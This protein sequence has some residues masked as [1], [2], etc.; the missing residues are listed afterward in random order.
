[1]CILSEPL[2]N[3]M[4]FCLVVYFSWIMVGESW[5]LFKKKKNQDS[6]FSIYLEPCSSSW[7]FIHTS[8]KQINDFSVR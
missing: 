1:M 3:G 2:V 7:S 5:Y 8:C 6:P 4:L